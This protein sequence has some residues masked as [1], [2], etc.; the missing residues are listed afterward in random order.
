MRQLE[1]IQH[2]LTRVTRKPWKDTIA[3]HL[4]GNCRIRGRN[5]RVQTSHWPL[6]GVSTV[7]GGPLAEGGVLIVDDDRKLVS[8]LRRQRGK[9]P[10]SEGDKPPRT[11]KPAGPEAGKAARNRTLLRVLSLP[12]LVPA[13]QK[14]A[15]GSVRTA[16]FTAATFDARLT[17][18]IE[19]LEDESLARL[20]ERKTLASLLFPPELFGLRVTA[21]IGRLPGFPVAVDIY[22]DDASKDPEARLEVVKLQTQPIE[23]E[24]FRSP[25]GYGTQGALTGGLVPSSVFSNLFSSWIRGIVP[26]L[27]L[28]SVRLPLDAGEPIDAGLAFRASFLRR[29]GDLASAAADTI[30]SVVAPDLQLNLDWFTR[31]EERLDEV[32]V[33]DVDLLFGYLEAAFVEEIRATVKEIDDLDEFPALRDVLTADEREALEAEMAA[34][35]DDPFQEAFA[36][37][38]RADIALRYGR[39]TVLAPLVRDFRPNIPYNTPVTG[40]EEEDRWLGT[41]FFLPDSNELWIWHLLGVINIYISNIT[42][43]AL[44]A[45]TLL[46]NEEIRPDRFS[47]RLRND[48]VNLTFDFSSEPAG[49]FITVLA[50]LATLGVAY[51][52]LWNVGF[53][54]YTVDGGSVRC[55]LIPEAADGRITTRITLANDEISGGLT[56]FGWNPLGAIFM[57][58]ASIIEAF[59]QMGVTRARDEVQTTVQKLLDEHGP[60]T[61]PQML[62]VGVPGALK[63]E[64]EAADRLLQAPQIV[65]ALVTQNESAYYRG[66]YG[67]TGVPETAPF[68]PQLPQD[69]A[70]VF[71]RAVLE[72]L[73]ARRL[74]VDGRLLV[75][76]DLPLA[77]NT[78][79]PQEILDATGFGPALVQQLRTAGLLTPEAADAWLAYLESRGGMLALMGWS[80]QTIELTPPARTVLRTYLEAKAQL[81]LPDGLNGIPIDDPVGTIAVHLVAH[82]VLDIDFSIYGTDSLLQKLALYEREVWEFVDFLIPGELPVRP[83]CRPLID[84]AVTMADGT[85]HVGLWSQALAPAPGLPASFD[86]AVRNL[87]AAQDGPVQLLVNDANLATQARAATIQQAARDRLATA[88]AGLDRPVSGDGRYLSL[89]GVPLG[90]RW[91]VTNDDGTELRVRTEGNRLYLDGAILLE[92]PAAVGTD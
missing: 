92:L 50:S 12:T 36:A 78:L 33:V 4:E 42:L 58:A 75:V 53:G 41:H 64:R 46:T 73:V 23:A 87:A 56:M 68:N 55:H 84:A 39:D 65:E 29:L 17:F 76:D 20:P 45:D 63:A 54:S 37:F 13:G 86:F 7:I 10:R 51:F 47:A 49:T 88:A 77:A 22:A 34:G 27:K 59:A 79:V 57:L 3:Q 66:Y 1:Q 81:T 82:H 90:F 21:A 38:E 32:G 67:F 89:T 61:F 8:P 30:E 48:F 9:P 16:V 91:R 43:V 72:M 80:G 31:L 70:H 85:L 62:M 40:G 18:R 60:L 19:L 15:L 35:E 71:H 24:T 2:L 44:P 11:G 25:E 83:P 74:D 6:F 69:A 26:D 28:P 14:G 52:A 5:F